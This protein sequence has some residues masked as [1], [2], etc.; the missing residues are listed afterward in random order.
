MTVAPVLPASC[1]AIDPTPPAAPETTTTS[2]G[3]PPTARTAAHAV[4]PATGIAPA[5]SQRT[6]AGFGT[7]L[8]A[9]TR[10]YSAWLDRV[11]PQPIT[12][13]PGPKPP[14]AKPLTPG[15]PAPTIP[16][17]SVPAPGGNVAGNR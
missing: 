8:A 17:R 12:R 13:G 9:S 6:P 1:T 16:A 10:A 11:S 15:L 4:N 5:T 14:P 2:P 3:L 7:R